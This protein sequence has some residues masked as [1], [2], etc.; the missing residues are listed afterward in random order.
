M[1]ARWSGGGGGL[2]TTSTRAGQ[3]VHNKE[4]KISG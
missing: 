2:R 4:I 3:K 1:A